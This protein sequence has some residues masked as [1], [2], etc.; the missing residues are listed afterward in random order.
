MFN[1][2]V[3]YRNWFSTAGKLRGSQQT[4]WYCLFG[5][6]DVP[7]GRSIPLIPSA[8]SKG[9]PAYCWW[10]KSSVHGRLLPKC[11][12]VSCG[13]RRHGKR[14]IWRPSLLSSFKRL[15]FWCEA[16]VEGLICSVE[17]TL[18]WRKP[19]PVRKPQLLWSWR[20]EFWPFCTELSEGCAYTG[21]EAGFLH[22][23]FFALSTRSFGRW[24][25]VFEISHPFFCIFRMAFVVHGWRGL[26]FFDGGAMDSSAWVR[27]P[28]FWRKVLSLPR[29]FFPVTALLIIPMFRWC[30]PQRR[31]K[32]QN[33]A[34]G[35][36][37][38][39]TSRTNL[40]GETDVTNTEHTPKL[41]DA[42]QRGTGHN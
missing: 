11:W 41:H 21:V 22:L 37:N 16:I 18:L 8:S 15:P 13:L 12:K 5:R 26:S 19:L 32:G 3:I 40:H 25:F 38:K 34:G 29:R 7:C 27:P 36:G 42:L 10:Q 2:V 28:L 14:P 20:L 31:A 9:S 30:S 1:L 4:R 24:G 23:L 33:S 17:P 6:E 39:R 35:E